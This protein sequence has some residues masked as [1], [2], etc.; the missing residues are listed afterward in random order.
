[1]ARSG[2][3]S[4]GFLWLTVGLL[5]GVAATVGLYFYLGRAPAETISPTAPTI[6]ME[7]PPLPVDPAPPPV[8][9]P[10]VTAPAP[11]PQPSDPQIADDAAATG[12]TGPVTP[13]AEQPTN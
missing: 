6:R 9:P 11:A 1:M 3:G 12:M 13:P 8:V 10:V 7:T 4:N 2:R 5:I